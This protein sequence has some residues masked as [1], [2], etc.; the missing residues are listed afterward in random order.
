MKIA[1]AAA[2]FID[3]D[4]AFNLSQMKK[5][6]LE[7]KSQGAELVCFGESFLQGF[8]GLCW[9][10]EK[11]KKIAIAPDSEAMTAIK[12]WT[13]EIGVDVL[14]GY[15]EREGETLY[16]ACGLVSGGEI[17]HNYRRI[18]E[19]WKERALTDGHYREG[20]STETFSYQGR[21]CGVTLC[22]DLWVYPER[23][24]GKADILFWPIFVN[25]SP[26]EVAGN[27]T[28]CLCPPCRNGLPSD[29]PDQ[30]PCGRRGLRRLR[31]L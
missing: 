5:Y 17:L 25:F 18:S 19:G 20:N 14:F 7:A 23:F 13:V 26:P 21:T 16:S 8:N 3:G 28:A 29:P 30:F 4:V 31:P 2:R 22:G 12:S 9:D 10:I 15:I 1:L 6:M 24:R 11:D 27:G